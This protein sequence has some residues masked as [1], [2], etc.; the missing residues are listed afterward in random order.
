[1]AQT[2]PIDFYYGSGSPFAWRVHFA[3]KHKAASYKLKL[4][5][6]SAGDMKKP[7]FAKLNPRHQI[8]VIVDEGFVLYESAAIVEYL[9]ERFPEGPALFPGEIRER[10]IVRRLV[11]E[12]DAYYF[13]PHERVFH[14]LFVTKPDERDVQKIEAGVAACARELAY[15]ET[16]LRGEF[17]I[18][19]LSAADFT[20]YP[21]IAT[22]ARFERVMP[23]L[24]LASQIGPKLGSWMRRIEALP[25]FAKTFPPHWR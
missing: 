16:E 24:G 18:G 12:I 1:M 13:E 9:E 11:R 15:F 4:M 22:I 17:L 19:P 23:D 5:S 8:P 10:A 7:E 21:M 2:A 20:L 14:E 25:F 6:F 3:L